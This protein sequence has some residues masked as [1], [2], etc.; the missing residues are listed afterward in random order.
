[1]SAPGS[2]E[3]DNN[4]PVLFNK[5]AEL[6]ANDFLHCRCV[7]VVVNL[8][9]QVS[10]SSLPERMKGEEGRFEQGRGRGGKRRKLEVKGGS[11]KHGAGEGS[12]WF[13]MERAVGEE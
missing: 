10:F 11:G 3:L 5:L 9:R 1:M 2:K 13:E 8:S 7:P 12:K 4:V 6:F